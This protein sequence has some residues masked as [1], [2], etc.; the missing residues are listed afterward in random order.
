MKPYDDQ[1]AYLRTYF[2]PQYP[3]PIIIRGHIPYEWMEANLD[4]TYHVVKKSA[5]WGT[6][7]EYDIIGYG[8][9]AVTSDP[10][11]TFYFFHD[12]KHVEKIIRELPHLVI[13]TNPLG[14]DRCPVCA[15]LNQPALEAVPE[16]PRRSRLSLA[17]WS[18]RL[19]R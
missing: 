9:S 8:C 10:E 2:G 4:K 12:K 16:P 13:E 15:G 14:P 7:E 3:H 1:G 6:V 18:E 5:I 17:Y 19:S 11:L